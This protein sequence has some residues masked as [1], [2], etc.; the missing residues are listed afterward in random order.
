MQNVSFPPPEKIRSEKQ[1]GEKEGGWGEACLPAGRE[2]LPACSAALSAAGGGSDSALLL[3]Q[4]KQSKTF[5]NL[6]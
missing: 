2:F 5:F 4:E 6:I 3:R 1:A